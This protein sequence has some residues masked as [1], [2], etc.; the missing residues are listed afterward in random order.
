MARVPNMGMRRDLTQR[1]S[2][3]RVDDVHRRSRLQA[4]RKAIYD[5]NNLILGAAVKRLLD[6]ESLFPAAVSM[7]VFDILSALTLL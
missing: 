7:S 1:V 5:H 3:A 6:E 2:L 4:A